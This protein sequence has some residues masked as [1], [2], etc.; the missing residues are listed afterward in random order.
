MAVRIIPDIF[1]A[2]I[3]LYRNQLMQ[4]FP[5]IVSV[6][7]KFSTLRN[8]IVFHNFTIYALNPIKIPNVDLLWLIIGI[9]KGIL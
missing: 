6:V 9:K 2:S 3:L 4:N 8:H 7:L 1:F 5:V